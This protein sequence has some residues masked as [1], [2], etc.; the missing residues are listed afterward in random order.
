[1]IAAAC[2]FVG[3]LMV[4][5]GAGEL[6]LTAIGAGVLVLGAILAARDAFSAS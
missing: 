4:I 2:V 3:A 6:P 1:M 5:V